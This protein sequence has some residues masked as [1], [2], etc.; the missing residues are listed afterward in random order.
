[1]IDTIL[2]S[3]ILVVQLI[4]LFNNLKSKKAAPAP[5]TYSAKSL[6]QP[7]NIVTTMSKINVN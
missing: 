2:L 1:M 7:T 3:A 4:G 5:K 6:K